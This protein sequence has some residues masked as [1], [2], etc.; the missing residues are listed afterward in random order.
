MR[1]SLKKQVKGQ[2]SKQPT[3]RSH[4]VNTKDKTVPLVMSLGY[5]TVGAGDIGE[6]EGND[7]RAGGDEAGMEG[8]VRT[9]R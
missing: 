8:G 2:T 6:D 9:L 7:E 5:T 4:T 1:E 3:D